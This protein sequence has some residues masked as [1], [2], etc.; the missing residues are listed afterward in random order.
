MELGIY[1]NKTSFLSM[2]PHVVSLGLP[3]YSECTLKSKVK[4]EVGLHTKLV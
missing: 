4:F 3:T 2:L 1:M